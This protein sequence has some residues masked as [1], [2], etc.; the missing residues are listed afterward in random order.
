M[1]SSQK[2]QK[3]ITYSVS[4]H[5][6]VLELQHCLSVPKVNLNADGS[7]TRL[8]SKIHLKRSDTAFPKIDRRRLSAERSHKTGG[9]DHV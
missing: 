2:S 8:P 4:P 1:K 9:Q 6:H 5:L 3:T 7:Q